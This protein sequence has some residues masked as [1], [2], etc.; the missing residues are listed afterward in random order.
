MLKET[1]KT[2]VNHQHI[3]RDA[4]YEAMEEIMT[5]QASPSQIGAFITALS[6]K[7]ETIDEIIGCA[8][9]MDKHA[10]RVH[11]DKEAIDIVGTGGDGIGTFNISTC[12]AFVTAAVGLPVAKHGNRS[13]SSR[14]GSADVLEALG[15]VIALSPHEARQCFSKTDVCFMFAPG[16]HQSMKF[17]AGPRKELGIRSIFNILGPMTNPARAPYRLMGVYSEALCEP[18]VKALVGLGVKGVLAVHGQ[19]GL[20]EISICGPTTVCEAKNGHILSYILNPES[21]GLKSYPLSEVIGGDTDQNAEILL[22]IL[23]GE[24]GARRDIVLINTAAALYVA[25]YAKTLKDGLRMAQVAIDSGAALNKLN[26]YR[27]ATLAI[28]EARQ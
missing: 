17:A 26:D 2:L 18:L 16:Y 14:C 22:N 19:D 1:I 21:L 13:V 4:A 8:E 11:L 12:S 5:G 24:T 9:V 25:D 6:M 23:K 20:D 27:L 7:G 3:P 10:E 28:K 15:I